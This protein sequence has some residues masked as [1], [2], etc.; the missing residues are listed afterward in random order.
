MATKTAER[1]KALRQ[2]LIEAADA[3]VARDG[4]GALRARDLAEAAGCALGAIY[5]IFPDMDALAAA[6]NRRTLQRLEARVADRFAKLD[7]EHVRLLDVIVTCLRRLLP[8][9]ERAQ[10][11]THARALFSAIHGIVSLSQQQ[12][13]MG[14]AEGQVADEITFIV[15]AFCAGVRPP[16]G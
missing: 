14:V 16:N 10:L 3:T 7:D 1:R 2:A 13:F 11:E 9:A 4:L 5:T 8:D 15:H 6:L 12:R